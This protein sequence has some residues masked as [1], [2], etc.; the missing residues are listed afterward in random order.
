M[1]TLCQNAILEVGETNF[2]PHSTPLAL[3]QLGWSAFFSDQVG[4]G[5]AGLAPRGIASIHRARLDAIDGTGPVGLELPGN[6]NTAD[7]A[8]GDWFLTNTLSDTRHEARL[9]YD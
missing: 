8:F 6:S 9:G 4:P 1:R 5:E 7:F 3:E 2:E